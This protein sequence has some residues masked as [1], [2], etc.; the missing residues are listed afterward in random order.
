[1]ES[2]EVVTTW[3]LIADDEHWWITYRTAT[4]RN[5]RRTNVVQAV[6]ILTERYDREPHRRVILDGSLEPALGYTITGASAAL[7]DFLQQHAPSVLQGLES[8]EPEPR[9]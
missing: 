7:V 1:M 3:H 2:R 8:L 6:V 5:M 9:A 4:G